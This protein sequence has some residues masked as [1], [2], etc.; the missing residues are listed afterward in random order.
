MEVHLLIN[1]LVDSDFDNAKYLICRLLNSG[2]DRRCRG[3]HVK[4]LLD[5]F[6]QL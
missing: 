1:E 2:S 3:H 6:H 4:P 5:L